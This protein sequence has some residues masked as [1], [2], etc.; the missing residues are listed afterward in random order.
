MNDLGKINSKQIYTLWKNLS[1]GLLVLIAVLCISQILPYYLSPLI[2]LAFGAF[3][4]YYIYNTKIVD[5]GSCIVPS[6]AI[7]YCIVV[8]AFVT[9][10][11]NLLHI[12]DVWDLPP[13]FVF[14]THPFIP[15]LILNPVSFIVTSI[16]YIRHNKMHM[17]VE[18]RLRRS[19]GGQRGA[20]GV[21]TH[22]AHLQL[23]NFVFL[24]GI[25][26]AVV[27]I[28]YCFFYVDVNLNARDTYI[29]TWATIIGLVLDEFYFIFRYY[30]LYLDLKEGNEL[31]TPVELSD[32]TAKTYLRFYLVCGNYM[33]VST[34]SKDPNIPGREVIDTP[35]F[36]K[37]SVNGIIGEDVKGIISRMTGVDDGELRFFYGRKSLD[38]NKHSLLRYF[39]FIEEPTDGSLPEVDVEGEWMKFDKIKYLY[40]NN[41]MRLAELAVY[42]ITRL[43]TIILT[44]KVFDEKGFRKSK[45]KSYDPTFDLYDVRKSEIDFQD[46]K[47]IRISL[48]NSDTPMFKLKK[49][50][51]EKFGKTTKKWR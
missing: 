45:I 1:I 2:G 23:R 8:Y 19:M 14:Y 39:Y 49:W 41:P 4:Y 32:M 29:F 42:D 40:S 9:I 51:R 44:E 17:C 48:F 46:D 30:N 18:C 5:S 50:W 7:L 3:L 24:S 13:E 43:A 16:I 27:W 11:L 25:L 28:Y 26:T 38:D 12:W 34:H 22:E 6:I 31:I 21:L 47:W 15:S 33:F 20:Q 10:I 35:F 37:Q 36:T